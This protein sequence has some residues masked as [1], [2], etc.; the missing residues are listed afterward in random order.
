MIEPKSF[1][2]EMDSIL[3]KIRIEKTEEDFLTYILNELENKFGSRI[4]I[5][6]GRIYEQRGKDFILIE[7]KNDEAIK[8]FAAQIPVHSEAIQLLSQNRSYIFDSINFNKTFLNPDGEKTETP[9]A[10]WVH[11]PDQQWLVVFELGQNWERDEISLFLNSVRIALNYRI[12]SDVLSDRMEQA[13]LIQRSLLPKKAPEIKGYDIYGKSI[14]A[15]FVGGDFY[16]YF[17]F[18][19][20]SFGVSLGDASGHGLPAALL[21]R[22]VVIGLR[23]GLAQEF[24]IVHTIKKLNQVIQQ[25]TY[26]T[27]FVSLFIGEIEQDGHLFYANAGHPAPL[28]VTRNNALEL[29]ATGITLGFLPEIDLHRG[30]ARL[31][32]NSVL[33]LYSDGIIERESEKMELFGIEKLKKLVIKNQKLNAKELVE[34]IFSTVYDFGNK[35]V[36]KDD[37]S[38]VI[39]K[40]NNQ[41]D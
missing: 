8:N 21:V 25:S 4:N 15:E 40:R 10:L 36:W 6:N 26:S 22:D 5:K 9:A 24:R 34:L 17:N 13:T 37:A 27:N 30:Y 38:I 29:E 28:L 12:F 18:D 16:D 39:I 1:F 14:S 19:D 20:G 7:P 35:T 33:V 32:K 23:M 11:S 3:A 2:R 41:P 31:F